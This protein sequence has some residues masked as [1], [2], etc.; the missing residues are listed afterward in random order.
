M[1]TIRIDLGD[2]DYAILN[3]A[4]VHGTQREIRKITQPYTHYPEPKVEMVDGKPKM[5]NEAEI[6]I[7][8]SKVDIAAIDDALVLGQVVSW[9]LEGKAQEVRQEILDMLPETKY[10]II[11]TKIDEVFAAPLAGS[12]IEN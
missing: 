6:K 1:D 3:P 2:G 8:W 4:L 11:K 7:D 12:G 9:Y 5:I 10:Q